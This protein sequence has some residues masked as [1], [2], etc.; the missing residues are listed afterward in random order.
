MERIRLAAARAASRKPVSKQSE[1]LVEQDDPHG[2]LFAVTSKTSDNRS[3]D[4]SAKHLVHGSSG[5]MDTPPL[6]QIPAKTNKR[7]P[8]DLFHFFARL[9]LECII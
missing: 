3:S 5:K 8:H 9:V 7:R 6:M 1:E 4:A 2:R